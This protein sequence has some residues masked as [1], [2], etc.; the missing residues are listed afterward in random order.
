MFCF[1]CLHSFL[2]FI[3]TLKFLRWLPVKQRNIFR[4]LVIIYKYLTTGKPKYF[5]PYLPLYKSA[6]KEDVVIQTRCFSKF[7]SPALQFINPKFI[8]TSVSHMMLQNFGMICRWKFILLLH[9]QV[10][11]GY[12]KLTCFRSLFL[13]RF[14]YYQA[15]IVPW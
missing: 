6:V 14:S 13:P 3:P 9:Y 1:W 2:T 5:A 7:P 11:K 12:L 10:S 15:P 4:T 8:L